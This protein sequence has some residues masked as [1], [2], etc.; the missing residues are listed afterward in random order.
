MKQLLELSDSQKKIQKEYEEWK[1]YV[2]G[3]PRV[4]H[5]A[6]IEFEHKLSLR[7]IA[8]ANPWFK[9]RDQGWRIEVNEKDLS[10]TLISSFRIRCGS[11]YGGQ[12]GW[13]GIGGKWYEDECEP[14]MMSP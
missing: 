3:K 1:S 14:V 2:Q 7:R 12:T 10:V 6:N 4:L 9:L 8:E 5:Q 11:W 13:F